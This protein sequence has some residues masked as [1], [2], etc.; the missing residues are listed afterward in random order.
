MPLEKW[1]LLQWQYLTI[2]LLWRSLRFMAASFQSSQDSLYGA[3]LR[4]AFSATTLLIKSCDTTT[5]TNQSNIYNANWHYLL[6]RLTLSGFPRLK[7]PNKRHS[8]DTGYRGGHCDIYTVTANIQILLLGRLPQADS[9]EVV[10]NV[11]TC[12]CVSLCVRVLF[13]GVCFICR[14]YI[15]DPT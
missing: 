6:E 3:M 13:V 10:F 15:S 5:Y 14:F 12:L 2:I 4:D 7:T 1:T 11:R 9:V 8:H